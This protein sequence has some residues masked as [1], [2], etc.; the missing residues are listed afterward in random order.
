MDC[1]NDSIKNAKHIAKSLYDNP[2]CNYA[3]TPECALSGYGKN[4]LNDSSDEALEIVLKASKETQTGLFLGTMTIGQDVYNDCLI[5]NNQGEIVNHQPKSQIIPYDTELGCK[6]APMINPIQL[7]D[8]VGISA[9]VMICNDFWGGPI[10]GMPCIPQQYCK[11]GEVNILIHCTNGARGNGELIDQIN[12]DWHNAWLQMISSIFRIVVIS[13]DNSCH[14]KGESYY[15]RTSSPSG[16][17]VAGEKIAGAP[18][19]GQHNFTVT[20][21]QDKMHPWGNALQNH[22]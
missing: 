22:T 17:W 14:M 16:C 6:P 13:V 3:I 5:I 15:G 4:C 9:G 8:H 1:T 11:G 18:E 20:L 19:F 2:E 12:W 7:P 21:P 10:G